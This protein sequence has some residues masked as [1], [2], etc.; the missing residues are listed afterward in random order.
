MNKEKEYNLSCNNIFNK[1]SNQSIFNQQEQ[2]RY[3]TIP[4]STTSNFTNSIYNNLFNNNIRILIF[5]TIIFL[6]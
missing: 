1:F 4:S 5:I 2:G 3:S 6:K